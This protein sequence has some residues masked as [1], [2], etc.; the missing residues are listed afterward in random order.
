[1]NRVAKITT[2]RVTKEINPYRFDVDALLVHQRQMVRS[3]QTNVRAARF[4]PGSS[5]E[6]RALE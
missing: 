4:S 3:Q 1:M 2:D 6:R 5:F